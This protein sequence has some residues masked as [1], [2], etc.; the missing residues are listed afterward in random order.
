[1]KDINFEQQILKLLRS[2]DGGLTIAEIS[3]K[4]SKFQSQIYR[5][6]RTLTIAKIV[7]KIP[8]N[9]SIYY[10]HNIKYK[11]IIPKNPDYLY[12]N[13]VC[14]RCK[15]KTNIRYTQQTK[16]CPNPECR[17]KFGNRFRFW[18]SGINTM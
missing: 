11:K 17:T 2:N 15:T 16:L 18:V 1:M 10:I 5:K 14:P 9:P 4:L 7:T 13:I 3:R 8:G 12:I 6:L